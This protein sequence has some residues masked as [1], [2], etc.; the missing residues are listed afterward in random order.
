MM[1]VLHINAGNLYGGI[2]T[3]LA[4]LARH[5]A[6]CPG[7]QPEFVLFFE[8]QLSSELR[9]A[10]VVVHMLGEAR[11]SRPWTVL[12]SRWRLR[13]I[14]SSGRFDLVVTH[15]CWPHAIAAPEVRRH[16]TPLVFWAH[17]IQTRW[18]WLECWA[19]RFPP[20]LALANSRATRTSVQANLF[21]G[22][23]SEV[24]YLPVS[25]PAWS[26]REEVR[27]EVRRELHTQQDAIVI[28]TACRLEPLKGHHVLLDALGRLARVPGWVSWVAGGVQRAEEENYLAAL[29]T[30]ATA[31]GIA[32][33]V[34]FLGQRADV[35][36]LL[37]AADI[38]CQPN[39]GPESFGI[40]FV[41]AQYAGLPVVTT[42]LGG[43]LEIVRE[44]TGVLVP[45]NDTESLADGLRG[46]ISDPERRQRLGETGPA[47]AAEL[48]N[49]RCQ[50]GKL[51]AIL[52]GVAR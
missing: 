3:L 37:A 10:G 9:G 48:C 23:P 32:D 47:A 25:A 31:V 43:A 6:L 7:V 38:H 22:A 24:L 21:P 16:A 50:M 4:T 11:V 41:E 20:D 40:A 5:G 36:R 30:K 44:N 39:V 28:V 8:G 45:P 26:N 42:A 18:H 13:K 19:R 1:R 52:A 46:L 15:G 49:P 12:R 33:R 17:G 2:E 27:R 34:R 29:R 14:L 35:G 51:S